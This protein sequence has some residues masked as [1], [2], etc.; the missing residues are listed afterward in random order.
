MAALEAAQERADPMNAIS[1]PSMSDIR[2]PVDAQSDARTELAHH[3]RDL[4]IHGLIMLATG[5]LSAYC[6]FCLSGVVATQAV[7]IGMQPDLL[8]LCA[9]VIFVA[10]SGFCFTEAHRCWKKAEITRT[11]ID[12]VA[13]QVAATKLP[14]GRRRGLSLGELRGRLARPGHA[15]AGPGIWSLKRI[16]H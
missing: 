14:F 8:S 12:P 3:A 1:R 2:L 10:L 15:A 13:A 11:R 9:L 16:A 4:R 6:A 5:A 7:P